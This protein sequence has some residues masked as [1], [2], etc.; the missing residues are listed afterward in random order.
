M[1]TQT[2]DCTV[3]KKSRPG[4]IPLTTPL[5]K[6][7]A[8]TFQS[9]TVDYATVPDRSQ[10]TPTTFAE[11][12][13]TPEAIARGIAARKQNRKSLFAGA[14]H[15]H[16]ITCTGTPQSV[17]DCDA[18]SQHCNLWLYR[19]RELQRSVTKKKL[20]AAIRAEC[21]RCLGTTADICTSPNCSLF[22]VRFGKRATV[23]ADRMGIEG[24]GD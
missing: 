21:T 6:G 15:R 13:R 18:G 11:R 23:N 17:L 16:C 14:I 8:A 1:M 4:S 22:G 2:Q 7:R 3:L 5:P 12:V 10:Q 24:P 9:E 19:T 20:R